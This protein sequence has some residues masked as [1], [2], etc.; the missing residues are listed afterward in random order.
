MNN[1]NKMKFREVAGHKTTVNGFM[2]E[3]NCNDT[4]KEIF[5]FNFSA[6]NEPQ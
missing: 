3:S 6:N 1:W 5:I 2:P 4:D